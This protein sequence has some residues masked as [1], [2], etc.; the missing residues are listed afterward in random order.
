MSLIKFQGKVKPT[1]TSRLVRVK[2]FLGDCLSG[3]TEA[4]HWLRYYELPPAT[5]NFVFSVPKEF[6]EDF[7]KNVMGANS[8]TVEILVIK[9]SE[10]AEISMVES[11]TS[12]GD[13]IIDTN[14]IRKV[15]F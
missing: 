10:K 7:G 14:C 13:T 2:C 1:V 11:P 6:A 8:F 12:M 9:N 4:K 3:S 15:Q 5:T